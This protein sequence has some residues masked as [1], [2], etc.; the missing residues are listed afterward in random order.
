M[1]QDDK[2]FH[3]MLH[4]V[5][6][7][8]T[9]H[10]DVTAAPSPTN[11]PGAPAAIVT[12]FDDLVGIAARINHHRRQQDG[13]ALDAI[14]GEKETLKTVLATTIAAVGGILQS[15]GAATGDTLL[16]DTAETSISE[17][18]RAAD[19]TTINRSEEILALITPTNRP[20]LTADYGLTPALEASAQDL[21]SEYA[22]QIGAPRAAI[23]ARV[24][25]AEEIA[26]ALTEARQLLKH[27]LDPLLR[28]YL[29]PTALPAQRLFQETYT[30]ARVIVDLKGK[31]RKKKDETPGSGGGI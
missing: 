4:T 19:Q 10:R 2:N 18:L 23:I 8:R 13:T 24:A 30:A 16:R 7:V 14:T 26:Q 1:T 15:F 17:I 12:A 9:E 3:T 11:Q 31:R 25:S 5:I 21:L 28:Q 6:T 27:R 20:I 22:T 29:L